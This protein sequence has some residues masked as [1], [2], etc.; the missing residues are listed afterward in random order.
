M[1]VFSVVV[2][3]NIKSG[4]FSTEFGILSIKTEETEENWNKSAANRT[5][6]S[7]AQTLNI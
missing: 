5:F 1:F 3:E 4:V 2:Q 7:E 6:V